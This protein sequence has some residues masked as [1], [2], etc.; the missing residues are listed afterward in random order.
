MIN[1]VS[2]ELSLSFFVLATLGLMT[3]IYF[4]AF[5]NVKSVVPLTFAS[6]F[7]TNLST[8]EVSN[9]ETANANGNMDL[10][11]LYE[12]PEIGLKIKYPDNWEIVEYGKAVKAYGDGVIANLLSPL[13]DKS[14]KFREFVQLRIENL[15]SD[16]LGKVPSNS[17]IGSN[18]I[19]EMVFDRPNL[20]NRSDVLR[21]LSEWS[22]LNGKA[23]VVEFSA[24]K[25]RFANY[26]PLAY[27]VINS[28]EI[29]GVGINS[30]SE[31]ANQSSQLQPS[32]F[33]R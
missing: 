17:Y 30:S 14:D 22:P 21:T 27:K 29:N 9:I 16:N 33:S 7:E 26:L 10:T 32:G 13:E 3:I 4:H 24:E 5:D 12:F 19:Y 20:A 2:R 11:S 23:F 15:S 8:P 28:I 25:S 6:K 31:S 18:P 1:I